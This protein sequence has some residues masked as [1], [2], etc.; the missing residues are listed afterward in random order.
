MRLIHPRGGRSWLRL[1][2]VCTIASLALCATS[3][4]RKDGVIVE[5]SD[6]LAESGAVVRDWRRSGMGVLD[7]Q[8][9]TATAVLGT[10]WTLTAYDKD[11]KLLT[12]GRILGPRARDGDTVWL[13]LTTPQRDLFDKADRVVVGADPSAPVPPPG[14][15]G[16]RSE[17]P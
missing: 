3:C 15:V 8:I 9:F 12:S 6:Q 13:R 16:G 10:A 11:G 7:V 17:R 4:T 5:V 2:S 14:R 1:F